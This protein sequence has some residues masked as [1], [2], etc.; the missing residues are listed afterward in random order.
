MRSLQPADQVRGELLAT[1]PRPRGGRACHRPLPIEASPRQ[2]PAPS[3]TVPATLERDQS[4]SLFR[5]DARAA[6]VAAFSPR[7]LS[8]REVRALARSLA[9]PVAD[10][11]DSQDICFVPKGALHRRDR[12]PQPGAAAV[13]RHRARGWP[14]FSAGM[15][16]IINYTVGQRRG[17]GVPARR[18]LYVVRLDAATRQ[19]VVGPARA[20]MRTGSPLRER[21][22]ARRRADPHGDISVAVRVRSTSPP[23]AGDLVPIG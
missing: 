13:G 22:L 20:C 12:A 10:K 2:L 16:G 9:L 21:E 11:S 19:V 5:Y 3:F 23:S 7:R 4:Y 18:P 15:R 8:Q 17:L 1:A 14:R 6:R